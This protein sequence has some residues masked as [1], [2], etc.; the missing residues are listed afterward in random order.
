[1]SWRDFSLL[2]LLASGLA[3]PAPLPASLPPE[4]QAHLATGCIWE[5]LSPSQGPSHLSITCWL[6]LSSQHSL[7]LPTG[8]RVSGRQWPGDRYTTLCV[9][10][11]LLESY[12][13]PHVHSY[14]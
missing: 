8:R 6:L 13:S 2:S 5:H 7:L 10:P 14:S 12:T 11:T 9:Y 1:V 3:L 4:L